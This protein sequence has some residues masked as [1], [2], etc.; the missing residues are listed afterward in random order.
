MSFGGG[1]DIP[2]PKPLP[3]P[4]TLADPQIAAKANRTASMVGGIQSTITT[5]PQGLQT[6]ASTAGK[7]LLG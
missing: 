3:T 2:A 6:S 7:S 5:G 1:G 4:P